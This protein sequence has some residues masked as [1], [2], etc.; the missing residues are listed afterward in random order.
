MAASYLSECSEDYEGLVLLGSYSTADFSE[1]DISVLS[2]YGSEDLVLNREKYEEC[3]VNLPEDFTEVVIDGGCHAYFGMYGLQ[4]GDG[5]ASITNEEQ[6]RITTDVIVKRI[7]N[8]E[9]N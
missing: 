7:V 1:S 4:D 5:E 8:E 3:K 9:R 6:I 2:I